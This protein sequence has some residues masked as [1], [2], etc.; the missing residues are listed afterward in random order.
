MAN[1]KPASSSGTGKAVNI[2]P[3]IK[4]I[5]VIP[6]GHSDEEPEPERETTQVSE[7]TVIRPR[8]PGNH[9]NPETTVDLEELSRRFS[10]PGYTDPVCWHMKNRSMFTN[11]V[12][13]GNQHSR[14]LYCRQ[15]DA[16]GAVQTLDLMSC[17]NCSLGHIYRPA[18]DTRKTCVWTKWLRLIS[19]YRLRMTDPERSQLRKA[20]QQCQEHRRLGIPATQDTPGD[21]PE[22][23]TSTDAQTP[24][25]TEQLDDW[26]RA[27][28]EE[29]LSL[30]CPPRNNGRA[31]GRADQLHLGRP[32]LS[33]M[34]GGSMWNMPPLHPITW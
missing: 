20:I 21:A 26:E 34:K 33:Q 19:R 6:Q 3:T 29:R 17:V 32:M 27:I 25:E 31:K 10:E 1:P 11:I 2:S 8:P 14:W 7:L 15:C 4:M 13:G 18:A 28:R 24:Q 23:Q 12:S 5:R 16:S 30:L 22:A 9:T